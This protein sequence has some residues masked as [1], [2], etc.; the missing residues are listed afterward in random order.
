LIVRALDHLQHPSTSLTS[1]DITRLEALGLPL[2]SG[3][4][5]KAAH[6]AVGEQLFLA[7]TRDPAAARALGSAR[8]AAAREGLPL[9]L[10]LHIDAV[11]VALAALPW[12]LLWAEDEPT[13]LLLSRGLAGQPG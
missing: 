8:N 11:A 6:R 10:S 9:S 5:S 12:E 4:L 13:P 2:D 3:F 1:A 7:L